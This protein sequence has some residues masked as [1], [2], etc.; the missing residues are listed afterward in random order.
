MSGMINVLLDDRGR[1]LDFQAIPAQRLEP[2]KPVP[3]VDWSPPFAAAGL[4]AAQFQPAEPLW[5][6]LA[7]ADT[8]MAWTGSWPGSAR[9]LRIEAAAWRGKPVAFSLIGPWTN[10]DRMPPPESPGREDVFFM[11]LGGLA[12]VVCLGAALLARR[13]LLQ[14]RGDRRGAFRLAVWIFCVLMTLWVC[15]THF[16]ASMGTFGMSLLAICTSVFYGVL[17]WT[18]YVALEP[19]VR[20][21]WP[22][23][24]MSWTSVLTGH[25]RDPIVGRDVL[26]GAALALSWILVS[27][28]GDLWISGAAA[29]PELDSTDYLVGARSALGFWLTYIPYAIRTSLFFFFLL[30]V[31]RVLLR[32]QWLAG[33]A[34]VLILSSLNALASDHPL[35]GGTVSLLIFSLA[36]VVVLRWGLLALAVACFLN[37]LLVSVPVTFNSSAWYFPS[38]LFVLVTVLALTAWA[39]RSS[40]AGQRL[41]K[42]DWFG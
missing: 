2:A 9:P 26:V 38:T 17:L 19:F 25:A 30:F 13:N 6:S 42:P 22:Q 39:F 11:I 3:P 33:A 34:F 7:A 28:L 31:L 5:T 20:R 37:N 12:V 24:L 10:P 32:N 4:D 41:W 23:T 40:I 29:T 8:R 1:L 27:R 14:G 15:K 35:I 21:H 36:A 18:I 16:V